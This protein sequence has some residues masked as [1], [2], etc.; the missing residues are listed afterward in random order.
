MAYLDNILINS[1]NTEQHKKNTYEVF[2]RI[3]DCGF[4]LKNKKC[5]FFMKRINYLGQITDK[6][7]L[8]VSILNT[9]NLQLYP[10]K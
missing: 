1:E 3:K 8:Q 6:D 10:F 4:K 7:E 5:N 2:R 9:N